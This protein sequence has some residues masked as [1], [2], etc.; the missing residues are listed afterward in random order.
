MGREIGVFRNRE[1]GAV[2]SAQRLVMRYAARGWGCAGLAPSGAQAY[3]GRGFAL[4][5]FD[6]HNSD[7]AAARGGGF[8]SVRQFAGRGRGKGAKNH[9]RSRNFPVMEPHWAAFAE[10]GK[11][12]GAMGVRVQR[13]TRLKRRLGRALA[14]LA[15]WTWDK[16]G[17]EVATAIMATG[18]QPS[19]HCRRFAFVSES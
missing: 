9:A 19:R 1:I 12:C 7:A 6:S 2:A 8:S 5:C 11:S 16:R 10:K 15:N 4:F 3:Q 14:P 17:S 13:L 18:R